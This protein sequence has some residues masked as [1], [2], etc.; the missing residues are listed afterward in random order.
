VVAAASLTQTVLFEPV[1]WFTLGLWLAG[2]TSP[3]RVQAIA[4]AI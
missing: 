3:D 4:G 1:L 2:R